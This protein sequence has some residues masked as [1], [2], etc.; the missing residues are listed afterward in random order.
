MSPYAVSKLAAEGYCRSFA[1]GGGPETV[2][3][4]YFNVYGPRQDP[5]SPYAAV[6]P[7]FIDA[8]AS[9]KPV[10]IYGDGHQSRDFTYV[11]DVVEAVLLAAAATGLDGAVLNVSGGGTTTVL[12]LAET[13]GSLLGRPVAVR[14]LP[15]RPGDVRESRA[16]LSEIRRR[17][18]YE[19]RTSLPAGLQLTI[20]A[21]PW[22][23]ARAA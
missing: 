2:C 8:I 13:V 4:R 12:Q 17:I 16:D 21:P 10:T 22:Q 7:R 14:H 18:G 3:L 9:G 20:A 15:P 19:P 23:A 1:L 6:V 11:A 5:A